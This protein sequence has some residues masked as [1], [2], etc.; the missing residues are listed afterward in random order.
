MLRARVALRSSAL[1]P[2]AVNRRQARG[3]R[4]VHASNAEA[5]AKDAQRWIDAWT[6]SSG[7]TSAQGASSSSADENAANAQ[8][9]ID[10]WRSAK[11]SG[12]QTGGAASSMSALDAVLPKETEA[13]EAPKP[14]TPTERKPG[15][16]SPEMRKKLMNE[17]V[18][19][20]GLPDKP[21]ESNIFANVILGVL[22]IVIVAYVGGIRP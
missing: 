7:A 18:G 3:P 11:G 21:M 22:A 4:A 12:A 6:S 15:G 10:A 17:S 5:N 19:L 16:I 13:R 9:W 14:K 8:R 2:R 20:G 1:A